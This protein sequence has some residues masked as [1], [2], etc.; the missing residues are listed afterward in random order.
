M[1]LG[2]RWPIAGNWKATKPFRFPAI[3]SRLPATGAHNG[4]Q[5][6]HRRPAERRQVDPLQRADEGRHRRGQLPVLHDRAECRRGAGARSASGRAGGNRQ[7]AEGAADRGRVRRHRRAGG[8]SR[9]RRRPGQQ[10]SRPHPRG[11]CDHARGA[12][13]REFR[14]HPRQQQD[15]SDLRHRDH[16]YRAGA[17]RSRICRQGI[18]EGRALGQ[19]RR[20]GSQDPRRGACARLRGLER[21]QAGARAGTVGRG[22]ARRCATC[23][24]SRS[25]R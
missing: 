2:S 19:D 14:C 4:H 1:N 8:R 15:R 21:G 25:S 17:G 5:M 13:L 3:D 24:C 22:Q 6:R 18:A 20:Q 7:A 16:R 23:S 10:V 12:L 9:E 11:R